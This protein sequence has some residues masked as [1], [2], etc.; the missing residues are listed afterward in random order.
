[1]LDMLGGANSLSDPASSQRGR[2]PSGAR[3]CLEA[4]ATLTGVLAICN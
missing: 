4:T 1:M 3:C 2:S